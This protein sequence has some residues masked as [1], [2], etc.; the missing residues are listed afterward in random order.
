MKSEKIKSQLWYVC[1]DMTTVNISGD[2]E[3]VMSHCDDIDLVANEDDSLASN[4]S[5][6]NVIDTICQNWEQR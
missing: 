6:D 2:F 3:E 4:S 1:K 5:R